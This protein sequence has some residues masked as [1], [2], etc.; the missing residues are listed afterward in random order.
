MCTLYRVCISKLSSTILH[1]GT[2]T[3]ISCASCKCAYVTFLVTEEYHT[4]RVHCSTQAVGALVRCARRGLDSAAVERD[5][6]PRGGD[7]EASRRVPRGRAAARARLPWRL[8]RG[9]RA[10]SGAR[11]PQGDQVRGQHA[12]QSQQSF[13]RVLTLLTACC[14][15]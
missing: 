7:R 4:L 9:Q 13:P 6:A 15:L 12:H 2:R 14:L 11:R 5:S 8:A 3:S 10:A 1:T